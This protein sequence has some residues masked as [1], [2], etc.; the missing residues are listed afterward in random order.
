M[1]NFIRLKTFEFYADGQQISML[2]TLCTT[3]PKIKILSYNDVNGKWS[4]VIGIFNYILKDSINTTTFISYLKEI[5][6]KYNEFD[7][8]GIYDVD[9][10]NI[11]SLQSTLLAFINYFNTNKIN[12]ISYTTSTTSPL[13][14]GMII[15]NLSNICEAEELLIKN[16][17]KL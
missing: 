12:V 8:L 5:N 9:T 15:F 7:V 16:P 11:N 10:S 2:F 13:I 6:I 3:D 14:N 4:F 17:I 1:I